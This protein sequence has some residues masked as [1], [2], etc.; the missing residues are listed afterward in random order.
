MKIVQKQI[1]E[2]TKQ[3]EKI[4][5]KITELTVAQYQVQGAIKA[6]QDLQAI[7]N[8]N[9]HKKKVKNDAHSNTIS[10]SKH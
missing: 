7:N 5:E 9:N 6:L 4:R 8:K 1:K 3:Y 2:Y 10:K